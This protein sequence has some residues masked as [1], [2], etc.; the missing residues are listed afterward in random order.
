MSDELVNDSPDQPK[1]RPASQ[2]SAPV[3]DSVAAEIP[4]TTN[5]RAHEDDPGRDP[6]EELASEFAERQRAGEMP[7][8]DEYALAHP[9]LAAEIR[10]LFPTIA[11]MEQLKER[12][13]VLPSRPML[14]GLPLEQ[15]GDFRILG[16]IGRGG[17]GVV[18]EAEQVS[19]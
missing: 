16:E 6:F 4:C 13:A 11:A 17:M 15:L 5:D 7:S 19:L 9:E 3:S 1:P 2:P 12:N 8:I 10:E 14:G 18:Y